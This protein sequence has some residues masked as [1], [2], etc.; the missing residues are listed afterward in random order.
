M[1]INKLKEFFLKKKLQKLFK[2]VV[3]GSN[4]YLEYPNKLKNLVLSEY[5]YIGSNAEWSLR[6]KIIVKENVI[7]GPKSV[8]WTYNHNY[9]SENFLP[10][11]SKSEDIVKDIIINSNVW[12]GRNVTILAGVT[13][14]EGAV[15]AANSTV[16]K[17]V[18]PLAIVAGCP[19]KII[20]YRNMEKYNKLKED[21][22]F[23]L[24]EKFS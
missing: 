13:V 20:K 21:N 12:V 23:Y 1:L 4:F 19:A 5:I 6:G 14:G 7:F 10:Y 2:N 18:P 15:L 17:S 3:F 8:L 16:V 24:K 9:E 11:G 22:K